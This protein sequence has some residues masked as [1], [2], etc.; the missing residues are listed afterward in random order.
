MWAISMNC[1]RAGTTQLPPCRFPSLWP[2]SLTCHSPSHVLSSPWPG[3]PPTTTAHTSLAVQRA[4]LNSVPG[5]ALHLK[6]RPCIVLS[7]FKLYFL[8]VARV[9]RIEV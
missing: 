3:L 7:L 5:W 9:A 1:F 2:T 6:T 8:Q 4:S